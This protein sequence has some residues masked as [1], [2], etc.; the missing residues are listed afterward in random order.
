MKR[1]LLSAALA[2]IAFAVCAR[3][4]NIIFVLCDDLGYGDIGPFGQKHIKTPVLDRLAAEGLRGTRH[5][6]GSPVCAPSRCVMMTGRHPGHAFVRDNREIGTWESFSGQLPIPGEQVTV[7]EAL[8]AAGYVTGC[9]GKWGLG[10]VGTEGDPLKQGFD[11][12]VGYNCQRHA[13]N[14]YPEYLIDQ[15][16]RRPLDNP[17]IKIPASLARGADPEDASAYSAFK[18]RQYAPDVLIEEAMN[19]VRA[20]KDKPF[21][22]HFTTTI[23]HLSLQVPDDSLAEYGDTLGDKPYTG[24]NGYLPNRRPRAAYAAM[25]SRLDRD[26]G[27]LMDLVRSLGLDKDTV[28]VFTSD[29]GAVYPLSGTDPAFFKSNG[30]LRGYKGD[31]YEG[32]IRVPLI[33]HAPGRIKAGTTMERVTGFEDWLPT[34]LE[35]AGVKEVPPGVDGISFAASLRGEAQ[36]E[37]PF[38]YREFAGYGGQQMAMQGPWKALRRNLAEP[39]KG[40]TGIVVKTELYNLADDP[41]EARD[42]AAEHPDVVARLEAIMKR[43]HAPS[44]EFPIVGLG[45]TA[46]PRPARK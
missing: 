26:L 44:A 24:G 33:V 37:R 11:R 5:Y 34:L 15:D 18:G 7:A 40:A 30:D 42:V 25:I 22:L 27:R 28:F 36:K 13:H 1:L 3:Q 32:G 43:E 41:A 35:L 2:L 45:E 9:F 39:E 31:I 19:F 14:F 10:G 12:F 16:R 6:S 20:N 21:Y 17:P 38:L 46:L 29:N 4:P 23:P 8:K